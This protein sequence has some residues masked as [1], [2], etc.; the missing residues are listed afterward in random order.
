MGWYTGDP[1]ADRLEMGL[2]AAP[3]P[4]PALGTEEGLALLSGYGTSEP[5]L[6]R[7][8]IPGEICRKTTASLA[9][10]YF[11]TGK[12]LTCVLGSFLKVVRRATY[13]LRYHE[14]DRTTVRSSTKPLAKH[15]CSQRSDRAF[16]LL[17]RHASP[18]LSQSKAQ[19]SAAARSEND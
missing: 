19:L 14:K 5:R 9:L 17:T 3:N 12:T 18:V 2:K 8:T 13:T 4:A 15:C 16:V 6:V 7:L 10:P 11:P 1:A